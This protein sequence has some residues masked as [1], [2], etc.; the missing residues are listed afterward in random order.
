[1]I[2]A[3]DF[4]KVDVEGY[5]SQVLRGAEGI[6]GG[7]NPLTIML[8]FWPVQIRKAGRD[9]VKLLQW[10][11]SH[12]FTFQRVTE[13]NKGPLAPA[14]IQDLMNCGPGYVYTWMERR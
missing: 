9:P 5:E 14:T 12:G 3:A 2:E 1:V 13:M 7:N 11:Q 4:I 8:E 6:I 10:L